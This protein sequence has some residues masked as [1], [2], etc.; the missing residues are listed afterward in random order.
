MTPDGPQLPRRLGEVR[1][2]LR[3]FLSAFM[4]VLT[5]GYATGLLFVD[6]LTSASPSGIAEQYRGSPENAGNQELKYAKSEDEMFIFLH[7]HILSLSLVF[8]AVGGIFYFTSVGNR[9]KTFLIVEPFLALLTT[10]GGI[11]LTRYVSEYFSWLTLV[12]GILMAGSYL[13]MTGIAL[14]ELWSTR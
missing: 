13:A 6:H 1:G 4:I 10:F 11:W 9:W 3:L 5:F 2:A 12:S 14:K 8:F 7:N